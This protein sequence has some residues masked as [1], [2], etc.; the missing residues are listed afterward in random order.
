MSQSSQVVEH[1]LSGSQK[2]IIE[3]ETRNISLWEEI[4]HILVR[5]YK[6]DQEDLRYK[7]AAVLA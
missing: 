2:G 3:I 7:L 6:L 5:V 4:N 1:R